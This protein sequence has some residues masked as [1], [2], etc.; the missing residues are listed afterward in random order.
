MC[1]AQKSPCSAPEDS[2]ELIDRCCLFLRCLAW[3][4]LSILLGTA[5]GE[6]LIF[7]LV[8]FKVVR[9]VQAHGP[10]AL[11]CIAVAPS[12]DDLVVV[13]AGQDGRVCFWRPLP[14]V[15]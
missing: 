15:A 14:I 3:D 5:L 6:M 1:S 7:D 11:T 8:T 12:V 10:G 9:R 4:G 13:T 2:W